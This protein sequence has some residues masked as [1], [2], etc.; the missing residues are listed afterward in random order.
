ME[1]FIG[2][3]IDELSVIDTLCNRIKYSICYIKFTSL[4]TAC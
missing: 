4:S 2:K 3:R 1:S